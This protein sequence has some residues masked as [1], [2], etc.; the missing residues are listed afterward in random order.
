MTESLEPMAGYVTIV[1]PIFRRLEYLPGVLRAVAAQDYAHIELI[2]SDNGN[3]GSKV[4]EIIDRYYDRPYRFR[5]TR[6]ATNIAGHYHDVLPE[7]RGEYFLWFADDDLI[8]PNF[9]S[10]LVATLNAHPHAAVAIARQAVIDTAGEVVTWSSDQVPPIISGEDFILSWTRFGYANYSTVLARTTDIRACDGWGWFQHSTACDD[11]LLVKLCLRGSVAF[12]TNCAFYYRWHE[13]SFGLSIGARQLANDV[14]EYLAFLDTD[15]ALIEY[16]SRH[17]TTWRCLKRSLS[18]MMWEAYLT[19]WRTM[20]RRRLSTWDWVRA[21]FAMPFILD[22]Y[23][24]VG[25]ELLG[26][27]S[28]P[29]VARLKA[30]R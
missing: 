11:A 19:R 18:R 20:Y 6:A 3:N 9:V 10:Q 24:S 8:S 7:A 25:A 29:V 1:V 16:A 12:N 21:A 28:A 5:Q 23:R 13:T 2:V 4:T 14:K 22:Y 27:V 30:R 15:P 17:G 26:A